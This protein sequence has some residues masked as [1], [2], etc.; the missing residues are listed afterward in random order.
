MTAILPL[1]LLT[2][3][4]AEGHEQANPV[5][6]ELRQQGVAVSARNRATLPAPT[7]ADGLDPKAQADVLKKLAG[8]RHPVEELVRRS[9]VAPHVYQFRDVR[10]SD[11]GAPA[12]GVDVWFIA[13]GDLKKLAQKDVNSYFSANRKEV[14]AHVLTGG[15]LA[16]RK[17]SPR[18]GDGPEG[19]YVHSVYPLLDRVQV[20]M[21][22]FTTVSRTADSILVATR[23]DPRFAGDPQFPNRWREIRRDEGTDKPTLGP[24]HPYDCTALYLKITRL[25][26]PKGALLVEYH[27]VS[28]EPKEWFRGANLLR[29]KLPILIQSEV[30]AFRRE[31]AKTATGG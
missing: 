7:M 15:E 26:E 4:A 9:V 25:A 23:L 21:T 6:K 13:Y 3:P 27:R 30:R 16:R 8:D 31:A 2:L 18:P 17:L 22:T 11:P 12:Y 19:R 20:E 28:T 24:P 14:Q 1:F 5:Y 10:P 29:S